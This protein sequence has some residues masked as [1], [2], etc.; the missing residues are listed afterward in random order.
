M[1]L[2]AKQKLQ[3]GTEN[4]SPQH[5]T[6]LPSISHFERTAA[7]LK[8]IGRQ[9]SVRRAI[10]RHTKP[11]MYVHTTR[12]CSQPS[13]SLATHPNTSRR[14]DRAV[15]SLEAQSQQKPDPPQD[16]ATPPLAHA[17]ILPHDRPGASRMHQPSSGKA[18]PTDSLCKRACATQPKGVEHQAG[19]R[20]GCGETESPSGVSTR[21][22]ESQSGRG[23]A[24]R[25]VDRSVGRDETED[26][27][28]LA[29][30]DAVGRSGRVWQC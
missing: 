11:A 3:Q 10:S 1:A 13:A 8:A 15:K 9:S 12:L 22:W 26:R 4:S 2:P 7:V 20:C 23:G 21:V 19:P 28:R 18:Q 6:W 25:E 17:A 29:A 30:S 27:C 24:A 14:D 16:P 5:P